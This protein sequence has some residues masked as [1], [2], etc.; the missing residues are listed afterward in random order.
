MFKRITIFTVLMI[1][2]LSVFA[3][4]N[5]IKF[6]KGN[7]SE[8]T[9][10]IKEASEAEAQWLTNKAIDFCLENFEIIGKDRELEG[11]AISAIYSVSIDNVKYSSEEEKLA[12]EEKFSK[13]FT[14]F[15]QSSNVQIAVLSKTQ[16]LHLFLPTKSF[17]QL[18]N[19]YIIATNVNTIDS[20]VF[21][22]TLSVLE[23]IGNNETFTTLYDFYNNPRYAKYKSEIEKTMIS[24]LPSAM[25]EVLSLIQS[26]DMVQLNELYRIITNN[27]NIS[28]NSLCIIAENILSA[29]IIII[30]NSSKIIAEYLNIPSNSLKILSEN[31]WTR[32]SSLALTYFTKCKS[33]YENEIM[34][35]TDFSDV[36]YTL[37]NISP[38]ESV[39]PLISYLEELNGSLEENQTIST[40]IV[41]AVIKTLGAI[42]DKAAF[43]SLLSVTYL[44]YPEPVLQIAQEA[45]SGLRW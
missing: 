15:A 5:R 44:D 40:P 12:L 2:T 28:K 11:L 3:A 29:S 16:S 23:K 35:E 42:G 34:S 18:L 20:G 33:L 36:I 22:A 41:T 30:E 14:T 24:L 32:S 43:D 13:I 17:V 4:D 6:L 45:L 8:K 25:D 9:T 1:T 21:K 38:I 37:S 26:A 39:A 27:S 10:A 31:K 19:E 7:I